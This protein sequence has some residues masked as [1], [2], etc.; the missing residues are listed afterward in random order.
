[1]K[2]FSNANALGTPLKIWVF[3]CFPF[4]F[5]SAYNF[6]LPGASFTIPKHWQ[7]MDEK[8][9]LKI[10]TLNQQD[11]EYQKVLSEF[12]KTLGRTPNV[13]KVS[14]FKTFKGM[15]ALCTL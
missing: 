12:T 10:V 2:V 5:L 13:V 11:P 15:L 3:L 4:H 14:T 8:E 1:M 6:V 7:K 9:N